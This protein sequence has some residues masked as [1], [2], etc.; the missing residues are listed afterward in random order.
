MLVQKATRI[1]VP[2]S[3]V[4]LHISYRKPP[5]ATL[6]RLSLYLGALLILNTTSLDFVPN[7]L[8]VSSL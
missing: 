1:F 6:N 7:A 8:P 2:D 3:I 5:T 4:F